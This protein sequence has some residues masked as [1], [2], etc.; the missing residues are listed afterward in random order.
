MLTVCVYEDR[1]ICEPAVRLLVS[2]LVRHEPEIRILLYHGFRS[3]GF[4]T[5]IGGF[6]GVGL[7]R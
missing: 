4:E 6:P 3:S 7:S 5:W 1:E 2:S